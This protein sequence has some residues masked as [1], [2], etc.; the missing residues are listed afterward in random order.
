MAVSGLYG[1][2]VIRLV[3]TGFLVGQVWFGGGDDKYDGRSG[4]VT[5]RVIGG[6]GNDTLLGGDGD[7]TFWGGPGNDHLDGGAGNDVLNGNSGADMMI[8]G[9]GDDTF[10][11]DNADDVVVEEPG[12]GNDIVMA[13]ISYALTETVEN[14]VLTGTADIAGT[15]NGRSNIITGNS[16]N[17]RLFGMAGNDTLHGGAGDDTLEG[18]IGGDRMVGG[19]GD[20]TFIVDDVRDVIEEEAGE[21]TDTIRSSLSYVLDDN[22]ENLV[23]TG[24]A[25]LSGTGNNLANVITGNGGHNRLS[26]GAG[27]DTLL[28][29]AGNDSLDGG[30]GADRMDGGTGNDTFYVDHTG[31]VV[32]EAAN[33]GT[34]T[35]NAS[36]SYAL[37]GNVENLI[38]TGA[39]NLSGIGNALDN[40]LSGN[41]GRNALSGGA[42]N[43]VLSGGG[44]NDTLRGDAG[45]DRLL[46]GSGTD[47]LYGGA[48]ADRLV[49]KTLSDSTVASVG[50]D[51]IYDFNRSQGD[52]IDLSA[53][54]A[55]TKSSGN[56]A[57]TFIGE[58]SYS[59]MAGELRYVNKNGDT[60]VYA[61]VNGDKVSDFAIRVDT[62]ID[63]IKGDFIL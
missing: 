46:G 1:S 8:G 36:R 61:D 34:D 27:H 7:E 16:G 48:G 38:L 56:Q 62:T 42:G 20:D 51:M 45:N 19:L 11:V 49:F 28:G 55:S 9:M 14:L 23:L 53:I 60:F 10:H 15:G 5:G 22:V 12:S 47:K 6:S 39:G 41:A 43:D 33:G 52:R 24:S 32:V 26:G 58:A 35:V 30:T 4:T 17:N 59:G 2:G 63:F 29:G 21:G 18:G 57:F 44:G 3:N 37:T 31:D 50:R 13:S 40:T 25:G 54:D